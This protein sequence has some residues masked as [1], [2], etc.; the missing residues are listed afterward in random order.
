MNDIF[1]EKA[2]RILLGVLMLLMV[3]PAYAGNNDRAGSA[4]STQLLM[5][6]WARTGGW[7]GSNLASVS[8]AE[9]M[10]FNVAGLALTEGV[11]LGYSNIQY[12]GNSGISVNSAAG[13]FRLGESS[14]T[15]GI[16]VFSVNYGDIEIT[17]EDFPEGGVGQFSPNF[18]TL[19]LS[20]AKVFSNSI[21]GGINVKLI[22]ETTNNIGAVGFAFDAGIDYLTGP[23]KNLK[24]G[25]TLRNVGGRMKFQG[26]GLDLQGTVQNGIDVVTLS[27]LS[28]G[29]E[30]PAQMGL[31]FA[32]D[33]YLTDNQII[34]TNASF[35]ANSF[36]KDQF[37]FGLGY[38]FKRII[39]INAGYLLEDGINNSVERNTVYTGPSAGVSLDLPLGKGGTKIGVDY[40]Y[41]TT[42]PFSGFHQISVRLAF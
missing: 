10:F 27:N 2:K 3:Y 4:G 5:L 38:S 41:R 28:Q 37:A 24:F 32:Y 11:D 1:T 29:F 26:D 42:N 16:N 39:T 18:L 22:S 20:Y 15:L 35:L 17:T 8:G 19:G 13:A 30:L 31:G 6:P 14:S 40:A 23:R 34:L 21:Y 12:M 33:I 36:T 25:I 9:A 7:S